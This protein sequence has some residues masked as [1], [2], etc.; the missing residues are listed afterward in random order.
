MDVTRIEWTE[1]M[2]HRAA[3]RGFDL[4]RIEEVVR[5][6]TE[7]YLDNATDRL[8]AVGKHAHQLIMVPYEK[9]GDVICPVT[10]HATTRTQIGARIKAG[11]FTHE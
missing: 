8:V 11:R 3:L 4:A 6:S 7:R 2:Q 9:E 10:V 5:Y 1:Y